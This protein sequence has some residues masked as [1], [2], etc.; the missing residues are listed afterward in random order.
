VGLDST[1][2]MLDVLQREALPFPSAVFPAALIGLV[3]HHLGC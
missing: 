1:Q 3:L 2:V